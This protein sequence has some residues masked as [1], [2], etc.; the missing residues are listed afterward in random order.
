MGTDSK[1]AIT[2]GGIRSTRSRATNEMQGP[3]QS[4]GFQDGKNAGRTIWTIG[5]S[6]RP[7]DDFLELLARYRIEAIADV[8]RFPGSR[9]QPQYAGPAL[10]AALAAQGIT[11]R[12]LP[13]L[14][15]RRRPLPDSANTAW[16]NAS[17]RGYADHMDSVEFSQGMNQLLE[18]SRRFSTALMC[19]E[20]VWWRCHRA[21]IADFL[22]V[23]GI[24]V[25]HILDEKNTTVHPYTSPARIVR[26]R[27]SYAVADGDE[28]D[29]GDKSRTASH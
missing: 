5:H 16:R 9:R 8:R 7:L 14:G 13:A 19:A 28:R 4:N 15:G 11:Y 27:L 22:C 25:V 17:F 2:C 29:N 12:W 24:E 21:L 20:A 26:G 23:S 6:T 3:L 18:L 1:L 10:G